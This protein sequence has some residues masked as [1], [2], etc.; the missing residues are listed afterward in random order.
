MKAFVTGGTGFI[1]RHLVRALLDRST[2][3]VVLS[4]GSADAWN[5]PRVRVVQGE[6]TRPGAWQAAV[7]GCHVVFNLAGASIFEPPYRWTGRRKVLIRE[8]RVGTTHCLVEAIRGASPRPAALVSQSAV[9]YYG[10]RGDTLLDETAPPGTD[11]LAGVCV[12]WEEAARTAQDVT[13]VTLLRSGMVLERGG[14]AMGPLLRVFRLGIG[15]PWGS[16]AQWWP[17]IHMADMVGLMLFAWDRS[18]TGA[19][20]V[21][22]PEAVQVRDFARALAEVLHRPA[23]ARVPEQAIRTALGEAAGALLASQRITPARALAAGYPFRFPSLHAALTEVVR[24]GTK[25]E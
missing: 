25:W 9:G 11:F 19:V 7:S 12:E 13:R 17:W 23:F 15:G 10:S 8:S 6:G 14:G 16:G 22:V 5:D 24:P 20:N 4:R 1:G 3:V 18:L 2:E 21:A